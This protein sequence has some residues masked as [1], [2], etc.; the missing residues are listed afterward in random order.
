MKKISITF[1]TLLVILATFLF[2]SEKVFKKTI[3]EEPQSQSQEQEEILPIADIKEQYIDST[4]TFVGSVDLPTPCHTLE[5]K[6]NQISDTVFEIVVNTIA[7]AEGIMCAQV[8]TPRQYS[9]S[10]EAPENILVYA[11]I[12]G[13]ITELSRFVVPEGENINT[14][15]LYIKG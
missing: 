14:F 2:I 15:E 11:N 7:P 9:A 3:I 10:F 1:V 6:V 4:Y 8:I 5:T 13:V 12:N